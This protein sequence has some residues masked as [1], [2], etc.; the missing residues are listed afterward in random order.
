MT[1]ELNLFSII[2][3]L[4]IFPFISSSDIITINKLTL[5]LKVIGQHNV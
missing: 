2:G 5:I 3:N 1:I 4:D